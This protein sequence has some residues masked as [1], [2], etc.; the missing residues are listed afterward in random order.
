VKSAP[1][2]EGEV[3]GSLTV[4]RFYEHFD[5]EQGCLTDAALKSPMIVLVKV[6]AESKR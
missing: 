1:Y 6:L 4:P 2:F 3:K 5:V